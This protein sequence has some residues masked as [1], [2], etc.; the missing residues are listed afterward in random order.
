MTRRN[1]LVFKR[2]FRKL[3]NDPRKAEEFLDNLNKIKGRFS[4]NQDDLGKMTL[5]DMISSA[6]SQGLRDY[7][8]K[9]FCKRPPAYLFRYLDDANYIVSTIRDKQLMYRRAICLAADKKEVDLSKAIK[10]SHRDFSEENVNAMREAIDERTDISY[11]DKERAKSNLGYYGTFLEEIREN[12]HICCFSEDVGN[13]PRIRKERWIN[14]DYRGAII[15]VDTSVFT[16]VHKVFYQ[17]W[18]NIRSFRKQAQKIMIEGGNF[19]EIDGMYFDSIAKLILCC[20]KK[21]RKWRWEKEWRSV[22]IG[23]VQGDEPEKHKRYSRE[24]C[25]P[26]YFFEGANPAITHVIIGY[27][28]PPDVL[29][30]VLYSC[31]NNG[32]TLCVINED[33]T[34]SPA[35]EQDSCCAFCKI[36]DYIGCLNRELYNR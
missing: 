11:D 1:D 6:G 22:V 35:K 33:N 27:N 34:L 19:R 23:R 5:E 2:N 29:R 20:Y 36:G 3:L 24:N 32:T 7:G 4:K 18:P 26:T 31:K 16:N 14:H 12:T 10:Q 15:C 30:S 25:D 17:R 9:Y 21:N 28:E 13:D 8:A